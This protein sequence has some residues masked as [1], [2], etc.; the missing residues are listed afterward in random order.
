MK[1]PCVIATLLTA[2]AFAS[3][4]DLLAQADGSNSG[5]TYLIPNGTTVYDAVNG[6]TWLTDANL[7]STL[8][9]DSPDDPAAPVDMPPRF[10]LPVCNAASTDDC[11]WPDG[12]MSY[13]SA[14]KWVKRMNAASYLG[15]DTWQLPTTPQNDSGCSSKGPSD[16]SFGFGCSAG[17]LGSL[18]YVGL[19]L[20]APNTAVPIPPSTVG[21][22]QNFQ[23]S[24]Y[25]SHSKGGGLVDNIANFSFADGAQGGT[26]DFNYAYVLPLIKGRIP[27]QK[28]P[29]TATGLQLSDNGLTVYD[30][31][32]HVTWAA[33]ANLAA[34]QPFSLKTCKSPRNPALCV[35]ADGSMN[36]ASAEQ[37]V[38]DMNAANYG[39]ETN[40]QLEWELPASDPG[41]PQYNCVNGN[42]MGE[43]YYT[44][45]GLQAG[46]PIV[47]IPEISTG[48]F[49][50]LQPGY[51]WTCEA[52]A[53]GQPC[54]EGS[55]PVPNTDA[56]FDFSFGNGF[57]STAR[58]PGAHFVTVYFVGCDLP[59]AE[60]CGLVPPKPPIPPGCPP[61]DANCNL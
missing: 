44:E 46:I 47:P 38:A 9:A 3:S 54:V 59:N 55:T 20:T 1:L 24:T 23:P 36:Y 26:N 17:A 6:V 37:F 51:Y 29:S 57:L 52:S 60:D 40:E 28:P 41:C 16:N 11:I 34:Q 19:G 61:G 42:P 4:A 15:H 33:D 30:P 13:T 7:A 39:A 50:Q 12:A 48:P 22:F 49:L 58:E 53:V 27:G 32:A 18:Y 14:Q 2:L 43:L 21:P 56:Q 31:V 8:D 5:L 35:A 45:L 10:G 25:W